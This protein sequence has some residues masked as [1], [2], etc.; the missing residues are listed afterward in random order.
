M[1]MARSFLFADTVT[2]SMEALIC[3][4]GL[5]AREADGI[6]REARHHA[7]N[8]ASRGAGK[9]AHHSAG[10]EIAESVIREAGGDFNLTEL[11]RELEDDMQRARPI[12]NSSAPHYCA[13]K[14]WK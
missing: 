2:Q 11:L 8:C 4:H 13:I 6:Q 14:S 1:S 7:A 10:R 12:W 5:S 9:S 3:D